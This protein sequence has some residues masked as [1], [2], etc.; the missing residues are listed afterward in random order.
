[1]RSYLERETGGWIERILPKCSSV[2]SFWIWV[3]SILWVSFFV[4]NY[5][6]MTWAMDYYK[7]VTLIL[8]S[9]DLNF[10]KPSRLRWRR[11]WHPTPVLLPGE[12]HGRRSLVGCSPWGRWVGHDWAT[13]LSL[14]TFMHWRRNWQPTPVFLPGESQGW[15]SLLGW[16]LWGLTESDMTEVS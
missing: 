1:M 15:G 10:F 5:V 9:V 14:F 3:V 8:C 13:S 4:L 2:H 7:K 11:Q 6:E 16:R 12:S